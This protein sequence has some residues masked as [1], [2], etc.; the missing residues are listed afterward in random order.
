MSTL[1]DTKS[2][3]IPNIKTQI[4][5][6]LFCVNFLVSIINSNLKLNKLKFEIKQFKWIK[7]VD[8]V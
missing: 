4:E 3:A 8:K 5:K 7:N 2:F 1:K 6:N